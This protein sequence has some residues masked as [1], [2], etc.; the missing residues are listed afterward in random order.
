MRRLTSFFAGALAMALAFALTGTALAAAGKL[1]TGTGGVV[2]MDK[3]RLKPGEAYTVDGESIPAYVTYTGPSGKARNYVPVE[4][5]ADYL[6]IPSGWSGKRNSVVLGPTSEGLQYQFLTGADKRYAK[7][8]VLGAKSGPFTE[9]DP[10][11]V[12][13]S[14]GP[15]LIFEDG[16]RIE[17]CTGFDTARRISG[18][19][20][21]HLVLTVTNDGDTPLISSASRAYMI[22]GFE[23]GL[24]RV[25]VEPGQT[26]TRAFEVSGDADRIHNK[27]VSSVSPVS[28]ETFRATVSLKCYP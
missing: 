2:V 23:G 11:A 15:T 4:M 18:I 20:G 28:T 24:S 17:S 13:T 26:L 12:D 7:T 8:P 25:R 3:V 27:F 1:Q 14:G 21:K 10:A 9:I 19:Y 5:V 22:N 6:D 16:T